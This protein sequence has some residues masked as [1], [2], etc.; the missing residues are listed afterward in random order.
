[1]NDVEQ[2]LHRTGAL[3]QPDVAGLAAHARSRGK[4]L[5]RRRRLASVGVPVALSSIL[6][7]T[8]AGARFLGPA[9]AEGPG[10]VA[11]RPAAAF[12]SSVRAGVSSGVL[13]VGG[14]SGGVLNPRASQPSLADA[15]RAVAPGTVTDS[16]T[17]PVDDHISAGTVLTFRPPDSSYGGQVSVVYHAAG[18]YGGAVTGTAYLQSCPRGWEDCQVRTLPDGSLVRTTVAHVPGRAGGPWEMRVAERLVD[19]ALTTLAAYGPTDPDGTVTGPNAVL[20]T[21]QLVAVISRLTP[22]R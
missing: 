19:G 3:L 14:R 18:D 7:G 12:V 16:T 4:V 10:S 8:I 2:L 20:T 21:S 5:R 17:L 9:T 11:S 13:V 1:M 6:V 15:I 22:A